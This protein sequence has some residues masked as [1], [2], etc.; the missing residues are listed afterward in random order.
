MWSLA[1]LLEYLAKQG[2]PV[3]SN[4]LKLYNAA[5]QALGKDNTPNDIIPDEV[6][7]AEHVDT[8]YRKAFGSYMGG[9]N[10][11][12]STYQ[13]WRVMRDSGD[14]TAVDKPLEGDIL[15]YPTGTGNGNL[16]NGHIFICGKVDNNDHNKTQLMSN[17][18]ATGKF[19]QNYTI[20]SAVAR[21]ERLGG[22]KAYWFRVV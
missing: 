5:L 6:G 18:S 22:Y 2:T 15:V 11:T 17:S 4:R 9:R 21:Y 8:I 13:A 7:C 3:E 12:V 10:I 20:E 1:K 14:F 19:E 16:S